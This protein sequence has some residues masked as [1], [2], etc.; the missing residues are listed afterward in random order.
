MHSL[1]CGTDARMFATLVMLARLWDRRANSAVPDAACLSTVGGS[2]RRPSRLERAVPT[3]APALTTHLRARSNC[4]RF[5]VAS[6]MLKKAPFVALRN[7]P[8]FQWLKENIFG[9]FPAEPGRHC[10]GSGT[11]GSKVSFSGKQR[12]PAV[13]GSIQRTARAILAKSSSF[14]PRQEASCLTT[15]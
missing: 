14:Q 4:R 13:S 12:D 2:R 8:S 11:C 3:G 15:S 9:S 7:A 5:S 6:V 10:C 1:D